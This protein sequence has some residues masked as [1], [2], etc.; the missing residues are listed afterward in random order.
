MYQFYYADHSR[1][2]E[3]P[4]YQQDMRDHFHITAIRPAMWEEH[5]LEC[6]APACFHS[7]VHFEA[8]RDGRCKR[9]VN[10]M[11][12]YP[13]QAGCC[14][15]A[16]HLQYRKWANMMTIIF[17]SMLS[18]DE[19]QRLTD[20][21]QKLGDKLYKTVWSPMPVSFRWGKIRTEEYI[22]RRRLRNLSGFDNTPDAFLFHAYSFSDQ[23]FQLLL[24]I[25]DS[26]KLVYKTAIPVEP[27]ENLQILSGDQF[28]AG[29]QT[30]GYLLKVYPENDYEAELDILW[31]DFVKG[32]PIEKEKPADKVK[33]VVWDLDNTLW[34]GILIESDHP[35]KMILRP[36]VEQTIK[37]LDER[38]I[39][40][41][42]AS[43]NDY[44]AAWDAVKHTGLSEY[45]LYPQIHWKAKSVSMKQIAQQL[46]IGI[47]TLV[48]FDDS[49]YER[50][51]VAS[52]H[53]Q[54]RV[55]DPTDLGKVIDRP[56]FQFVVTEESRQ[57]RKMYQAEE[58]RRQLFE[59]G[60]T[61]TIDFLRKCHL[62][63]ELFVPETEEEITRCYELLVRTNQLN[64]S[65]KKYTPAE[66][67]EVLHRAGHVNFAFSSMDDFGSYGIVGYGQY[68]VKKETLCF[69]EFAMSCRVAGKFIEGA[70]FEY[71]LDR[72]HCAE[73]EFP[74]RITKK[75]ILLRRTLT[76]TGFQTRLEDE[77]MAEYTY[78]RPLNHSDVVV[79][80]E[81][82]NGQ[83][84]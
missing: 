76:E 20:H 45:F 55:Y 54:V 47:D 49:V 12:V 69:T 78:S 81:R 70:L 3:I 28:P 57:R 14:G 7:C 46:N 16:M 9:F 84:G 19:Y 37:T 39:L 77:N 51:Q 83:S 25:Y 59:A 15:Q 52:V 53:P 23:S 35:E 56:E 27:G 36:E 22:R 41:S 34:D 65:G 38:G 31:C 80:T 5:C 63:L 21:N 50:R 33:C 29:S 1:S 11:F 48:L 8:R 68:Q 32:T 17:P 58:M 62:R 75:N 4:K 74:I 66:F 79:V 6:S 64:M 24:E 18:T 44:D 26:S 43:K 60:D 10:G 13:S 2:P 42:I 71:L 40:Q 61:D 82:E 30:P 73:G 72:E 67:D